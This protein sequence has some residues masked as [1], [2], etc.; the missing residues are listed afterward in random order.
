MVGVF[1]VVVCIEKP[2]G[3]KMLLGASP[4]ATVIRIAGTQHWNNAWPTGSGG[5]GQVRKRREHR[6]DARAAALSKDY[7]LRNNSGISRY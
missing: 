1:A 6:L 4:T 5:A 7:S 3:H 2:A